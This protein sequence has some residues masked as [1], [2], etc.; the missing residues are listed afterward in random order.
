MEFVNYRTDYLF[1]GVATTDEFNRNKKALVAK[2]TPE[3]VSFLGEINRKIRE[4]DDYP[5]STIEFP[6]YS[7]GRIIAIDYDGIERLNYPYNILFV[8]LSSD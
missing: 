8:R 3:F 1:L 6:L 2:I 7:N 5:A 4:V